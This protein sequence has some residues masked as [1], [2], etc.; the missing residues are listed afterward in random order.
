MR[1]RSGTALRAA[2]LLALLALVACGERPQAAFV[3]APWDGDAENGRLL[4]RQFGCGDCHQIP[5]VPGARGRVG[6]PL[7]RLARRSYLA[8][9][10]PN[11][12]AQL[13]HWI[14]EPQA[15]RPGTA[16]PD[17]Q[18][19]VAHARDMVAYLYTLH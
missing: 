1:S 13:S 6:P 12:P 11:T 19:S 15:I 2:T 10:L 16:M 8:G 4:L 9:M 17:M 3:A 7:D 5:G 14:R 18:V